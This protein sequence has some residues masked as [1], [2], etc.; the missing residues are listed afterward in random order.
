MQQLGLFA[1]AVAA[2]ST[3][4][5]TGCHCRVITKTGWWAWELKLAVAMFSAPVL[6]WDPVLLSWQ[7]SG[8]PSCWWMLLLA[9]GPRGHCMIAWRSA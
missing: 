2:D 5:C 7:P 1:F 4:G 6:C 9:A 3:P 8:I